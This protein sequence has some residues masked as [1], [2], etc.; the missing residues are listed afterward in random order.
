[1]TGR[2]AVLTHSLDG[3]LAHSL[4]RLI[5]FHSQHI[6]ILS[7][8]LI[9]KTYVHP[10]HAAS[11]PIKLK[12]HKINVLRSWIF[13][14]SWHNH[15]KGLEH[16]YTW[17]YSETTRAYF[18]SSSP[19]SPPLCPARGE[20]SEVMDYTRAY[21]FTIRQLC[22]CVN[23]YTYYWQTWLFTLCKSFNP[24]FTSPHV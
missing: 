12:T 11:T 1:M 19:P 6:P 18:V 2:R 17:R 22:L 14:T 4:A 7:S 9:D 23:I 20:V 15:F 10:H 21:Y 8:Q 5:I 16:L 13:Y 3:S 24:P